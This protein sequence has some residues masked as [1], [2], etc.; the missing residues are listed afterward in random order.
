M[1]A[2][3]INDM[4]QVVGDCLQPMLAADAQF[5]DFFVLAAAHRRD[6]LRRIDAGDDTAILKS[7]ESSPLLASI[8]PIGSICLC[9][10]CRSCCRSLIVHSGFRTS[11]ILHGR[12]HIARR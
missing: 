7:G 3:L 10:R 4:V 1:L 6:L 12:L 11:P 8:G 9:I 5:D 2:D